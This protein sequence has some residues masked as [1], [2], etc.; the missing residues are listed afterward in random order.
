M[1][2]D[3]SPGNTALCRSGGIPL[4]RPHMRTSLATIALLASA[5]TA[6]ADSGPT[7]AAPFAAGASRSV[8]LQRSGTSRPF[9]GSC[10][11]TFNA[12]SFP[13]PAIHHQI[14][15][16]TCHFTHLGLTDFYGEQDINF[17]AGTQS[18]WRTLTAANGDQLSLTN[19][20]RNGGAPVGGLVSIDAQFVIVGGTGRFAGATGSGHGIGVANLITRTTTITIDGSISY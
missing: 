15:T 11:L 4:W 17:A 19:S 1:D 9:S 3:P 2:R 10:T 5:L 14:D 20:G 6:C 16:G 8:D 12:P 7:S 13:P 18:G